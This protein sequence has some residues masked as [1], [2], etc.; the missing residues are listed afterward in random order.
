MKENVP[1]EEK[2]YISVEE[3]GEF[4]ETSDEEVQHLIEDS[5][6]HAFKIGEK[7]IR[8]RKDQVS[9]LKAKW[10]INRELF[11]ENQDANRHILVVD[12]PRL[13]DRLRDFFYFKD[14]YILS[15]LLV[16]VLIYLILRP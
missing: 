13:K 9:E 16:A 2:N 6:L 5:I 12:R 1:N 10:R 8:V 14:F 3:A 7:V 15:I 11:P 4:L